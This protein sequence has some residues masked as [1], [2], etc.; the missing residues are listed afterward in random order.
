LKVKELQTVLTYYVTMET[1]NGNYLY[2]T[3][4]TGVWEVLTDGGVFGDRWEPVDDTK[5]DNKL[6]ENLQEVL[7][8]YLKKKYLPN[9]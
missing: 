1:V 3:D 4:W 5:R 7:T 2:R 6:K 9:T 8:E